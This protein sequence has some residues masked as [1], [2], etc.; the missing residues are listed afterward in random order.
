[1]HRALEILTAALLVVAGLG[2]HLAHA[3]VS[4]GLAELKYQLDDNTVFTA[5][6]GD[7]LGDN[8]EF[9]SSVANIGDLDGDGVNDLAV[10]QR[11][12]DDGGSQNGAV[13]IL[14][15]NA[16]GSVKAPSPYKLSE[17][18]YPGVLTLSGDRFG[19]ALAWLGDYDGDG[20]G[21]LAV[22][23]WGADSPTNSG[24]V[25]IVD[26]DS[27]AVPQSAFRIFSGATNFTTLDRPR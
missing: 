11:L 1:M 24:A 22:G 12:N 18:T 6:P 20:N 5:S 15:L 14:L 4:Q 17:G 25:W 10:G 7:L 8:D 3:S 23:E 26:L 9:G 2:V 27:N 21:E 16:D 19:A 13:Y